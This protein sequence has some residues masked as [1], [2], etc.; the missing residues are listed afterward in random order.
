MS[1]YIP[2][3]GPDQ[4]PLHNE[5]HQ[6]KKRE[7][8]IFA[9]DGNKC[10]NCGRTS[11]QLYMHVIDI[12]PGIEPWKYPADMFLTLCIDCLNLEKQ[13]RHI[14]ETYLCTT[15]RHKRFTVDDMLRLSCNINV[16]P[17]FTASLLKKLRNDDKRLDQGA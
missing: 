14:A 6:W 10:K 5:N 9:R 15:L 16:D 3:A 8:E 1:K 17:T 12:I 2:P 7:A 11:E 13:C 4:C